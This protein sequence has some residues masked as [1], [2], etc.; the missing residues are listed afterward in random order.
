MSCATPFVALCDH[1]EQI[2]AGSFPIGPTHLEGT[3]FEVFMV[4]RILI[5]S[6]FCQ[7]HLRKFQSE[8]FRSCER[9]VDFA[10]SF[11][12]VETPI[13]FALS[14]GPRVNGVSLAVLSMKLFRIFPAHAE[15]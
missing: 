12:S 5:L 9:P 4:V 15:V 8:L 6:T 3:Y 13:G 14:T 7:F 11:S 2:S 1:R 10:R